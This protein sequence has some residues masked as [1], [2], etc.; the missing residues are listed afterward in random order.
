MA[1]GGEEM[2]LRG[3]IAYAKKLQSDDENLKKDSGPAAIKGE[4][5]TIIFMINIDVM[6]T[7][8]GSNPFFAFGH[9]DI[10]AS[11]RLLCAETCRF[12]SVH[13]GTA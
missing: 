8:L 5:D 2:G 1:F 12:H 13:D 6:G 11:V 9:P 7:K 4:L 10:A 3:S